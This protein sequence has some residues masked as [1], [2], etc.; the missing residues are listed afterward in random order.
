MARITHRLYKG[1]FVVAVAALAAAAIPSLTAQASSSTDPGAPPQPRDLRENWLERAWFREQRAYSRLS[2]MFEHAQ[3]RIERGQELIDAAASRGKDT[4]GLQA[5]LDGFAEAIQATRP[6]LASAQA[7]ITA[8]NGFDAEGRVTNAD[9]AEETVE[10]MAEQLREIRD[11]LL[12]PTR[13]VG[14]ALR[15]FREANRPD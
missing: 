9:V 8:H 6:A 10:G 3:Q 4:A 14:D 11:A 12:N 2:F 1:L 15:A 13:A 5:V 7:I